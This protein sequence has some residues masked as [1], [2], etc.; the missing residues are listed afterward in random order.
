MKWEDKISIIDKLILV[1]K[2]ISDSIKKQEKEKKE[3]IE[4]NKKEFDKWKSEKRLFFDKK[5]SIA[6]KSNR[7]NMNNKLREI[8][9]KSI[10]EIEIIK[11][12]YNTNKDRIINELINVI[13]GDN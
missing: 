8:E 1:D 10:E 3:D 4:F 5:I 6:L 12:K 13:R 2:N 7:E 9:Q 11:L